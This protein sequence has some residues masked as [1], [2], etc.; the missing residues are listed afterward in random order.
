MVAIVTHPGALPANAKRLAGHAGNRQKNP[1][2]NDAT[3]LPQ[4]IANQVIHTPLAA[5]RGRTKQPGDGPFGQ[6]LF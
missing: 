6:G 3:T 5:P 2:N 4:A 1:G